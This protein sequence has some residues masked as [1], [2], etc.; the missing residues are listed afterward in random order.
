[1]IFLMIS[2][3][4]FIFFG[5]LGLRLICINGKGIVGGFSLVSI[6]IL[7]ISF[8]LILFGWFVAFWVLKIDSPCF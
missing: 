8:I 5:D 6:L 1:M 7:P 3:M 2:L 4:I